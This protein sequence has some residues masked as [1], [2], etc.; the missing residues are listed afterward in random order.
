MLCAATLK[1]GPLRNGSAFVKR[2]PKFK[3]CHNLLTMF[4]HAPPG[5][6]G[7]R[8]MINEDHADSA[9]SSQL[10]D[11]IMSLSEAA[12]HLSPSQIA[13]HVDDIRKIARDHGLSV[14]AEIAHGLESALARSDSP[15]VIQ[16]WLKVMSEAA[17]AHG[18]SEAWLA[19]LGRR[20]YG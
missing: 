4:A 19:S 2:A 16:S 12:A 13:N 8:V 9:I 3:R 15:L 18:S 11:Q 20:L 17:Y 6:T 14:L 1:R 5:A 10:R 7:E